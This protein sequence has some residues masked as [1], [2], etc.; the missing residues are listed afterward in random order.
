[1][2]SKCKA[3]NPA[4]C[5]F[6]SGNPEVFKREWDVAREHR[7]NVEAK[8]MGEKPEIWGNI[9]NSV[10]SMTGLPNHVVFS[11]EWRQ[12]SISEDA[13]RQAYYCTP[14]GMAE[15]KSKIRK[16]SGREKESLK[17]SLIWAKDALRREESKSR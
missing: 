2:S 5:R 12:A 15:L 1:M 7:E 10:D 17:N 11:S 16:A 13:R 9:P 8:L 14:Q 4:S 3:K 6:H